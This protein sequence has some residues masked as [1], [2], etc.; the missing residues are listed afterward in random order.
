L[1]LIPGE[2]TGRDIGEWINWQW[3]WQAMNGSPTGLVG[4][5]AHNAPARHGPWA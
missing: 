2:H 4:D 3:L 5:L 1:Q